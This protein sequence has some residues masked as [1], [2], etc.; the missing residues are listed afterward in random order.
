M[1]MPWHRP[2]LDAWSIIGMNHYTLE[3]RRHLFVAMVSGK[4][5]IRAEGR[6]EEAVF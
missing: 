4:R 3:G 6:D 2:E 1:K 5:W